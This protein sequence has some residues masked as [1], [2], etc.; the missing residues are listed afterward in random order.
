MELYG[1][2]WYALQK[3]EIKLEI[4]GFFR[5]LPGLIF[6]DI[7]QAIF[8]LNSLLPNAQIYAIIILDGVR[9]HLRFV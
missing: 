4:C 6:L 2:M 5:F 7:G 9:E 8:L 3:E 1:I